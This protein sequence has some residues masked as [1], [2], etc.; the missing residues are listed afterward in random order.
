MRDLKCFKDSQWN[1][2]A[3]REKAHSLLLYNQRINPQPGDYRYPE[4]GREHAINELAQQLAGALEA[5]EANAQAK[6][7]STRSR[8]RVDE[9]LVAAYARIAQTELESGEVA[10]KEIYQRLSELCSECAAAQP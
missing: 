6:D 5:T 10:A 3:P 2:M 4:G 7:L 8:I 1:K 9:F